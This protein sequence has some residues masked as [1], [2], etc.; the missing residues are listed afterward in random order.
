[1]DLLFGSAQVFGLPGVWIQARHAQGSN[2]ESLQK[3]PQPLCLAIG[4]SRRRGDTQS[5]DT[6]VDQ[7]FLPALQASCYERLPLWGVCGLKSV[8]IYQ[9]GTCQKYQPKRSRELLSRSP[10]GPHP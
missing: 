9:L 3:T 1:M 7:K 6:D 5:L 2:Y 10:Q 4:F 8:N